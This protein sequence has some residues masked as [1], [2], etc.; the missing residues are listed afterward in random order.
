VALEYE[1][2]ESNREIMKTLVQRVIADAAEIEDRSI[3]DKVV[4]ELE[5][6]LGH[7]PRL[8]RMGILAFLRLVEIG[9]VGLG[10]RHTFIHLSTEDQLKYLNTM[11]TSRNYA[12]RGI[13]MAL[14]SLIILVY[15]SEPEAERAIGYDRS[16]LLKAN[17]GKTNL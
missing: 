7:L 17:E 3:L 1:L 13:I 8:H 9:P 11:E 12:L 2:G 4:E 16:C 6:Y 5:Q 14:K 15:F 10:F